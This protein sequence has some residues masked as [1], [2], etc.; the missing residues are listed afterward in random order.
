MS[1]MICSNSV[2]NVVMNIVMMMT[3]ALTLWPLVV[4]VAAAVGEVAE[5]AAP[6]TAGQCRRWSSIHSYHFRIVCSRPSRR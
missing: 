1:G 4:V 6:A 3:T 2:M 5:P